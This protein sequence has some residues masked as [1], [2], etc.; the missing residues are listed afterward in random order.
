[1][2]NNLLAV[3]FLIQIFSCILA[4][5]NQKNITEFV[6]AARN[7]DLDTVKKMLEEKTVGINDQAP[8]YNNQTALI[9]SL[10]LEDRKYDTVTINKKLEVARYLLDLEA[11]RDIG[12]IKEGMLWERVPLKDRIISK[13]SAL[14]EA[15]KAI[16]TIQFNTIAPINADLKK[17]KEL[18]TIRT[19]QTNAFM[20]LLYYIKK[21]TID[22]DKFLQFSNDL[23]TVSAIAGQ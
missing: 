2:K 16:D 19:E 15:K 4:Q 17:Q 21:T 23:N 13:D 18:N 5:E 22:A 10:Y 7:G 11:N 20:E 3:I 14:Q 1:M 9:G 12:G 6:K 8:R